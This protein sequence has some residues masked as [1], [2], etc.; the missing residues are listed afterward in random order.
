VNYFPTGEIQ[1]PN[2]SF[3]RA[4][5]QAD[6]HV[7][8]KGFAHH[9]P[10]SAH[11]PGSKGPTGR[12]MGLR[13]YPC[14]TTLCGY[15]TTALHLAKGGTLEAYDTK[16][17]PYEEPGSTRAY[18][19]FSKAVG[20]SRG[21]LITTK[22]P[23]EG[24]TPYTLAVA[25]RDRATQLGV[26]SVD[27][28]GR[29]ALG[30]STA[31]VL[32]VYPHTLVAYAKRLSRIAK[33]FN[34]YQQFPGKRL[35]KVEAQRWAEQ[36]WKVHSSLG[37]QACEN[38]RKQDVEISSQVVCRDGLN[39]HDVFGVMIEQLGEVLDTGAIRVVK[40]PQSAML[41]A[42]SVLLDHI[43]EHTPLLKRYPQN[44][45]V[46]NDGLALVWQIMSSLGFTPHGVHAYW[47]RNPLPDWGVRPTYL[48][49][50]NLDFS[51]LLIRVSPALFLCL[52]LSRHFLILH[53]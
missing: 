6:V 31:M 1:G 10:L 13:T 51:S 5:V 12:T 41:Q 50:F 22:R 42:T 44:T 19:R 30:D 34:S 53:D 39:A 28:L 37:D 16:H 7:Q 38:F 32:D 23:L 9:V 48:K 18:L 8:S 21:H 36:L 47:T 27:V 35:R 45:I 40:V 15:T 46:C 14:F 49:F 2:G 52:A 26:A 33:Y 29:A 20:K 24:E 43:R 25:Q 4:V 3:K 17:S 11:E